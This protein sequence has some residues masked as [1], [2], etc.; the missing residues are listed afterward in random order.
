[1]SVAPPIYKS[2]DLSFKDIDTVK[3]IVQGYFASFNTLDA[4]GDIFAPT[5]FNN[6]I[7][8]VGPKSANPRIK[9]FLDHDR[10]NTVA[11]IQELQADNFGLL[12]TS[13]A[14]SHTAGQDFL[15]MCLDGI[16]TEHSVGIS[17]IADKMRGD[18]NGNTILMEVKLWEGSSLQAWGAN[19][20]TP[21][22]GVKSLEGALDY[23]LTLEKALKRGTYT[24]EAFIHLE[25]LHTQIGL[26]LKKQTT[27]PETTTQPETPEPQPFDSAKF[28]KELSTALKQ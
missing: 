21:L 7:Q 15:K 9:H 10:R 20:Q 2:S 14:G 18:E 8:Q 4:D 11:V 13:K 24:D 16:I 5:A 3:G 25:K 19:S 17:Y 1:M 12:Y 6:S 27:E 22:L 23:F 26:M 28:L